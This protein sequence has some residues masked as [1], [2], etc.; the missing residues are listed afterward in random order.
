VYGSRSYVFT[1]DISINEETAPTMDRAAFTFLQQV[2]ALSSYKDQTLAIE[3]GSA[4]AAILG[5]NF[6]VT[7]SAAVSFDESFTHWG[8]EDNEF[9][10]RL[11]SSHGYE[12]VCPPGLEVIGVEPGTEKQFSSIRPKTSEEIEG[13]IADLV[14][15]CRQYPTVDLFFAWYSLRFFEFNPMTRRW[16][17]NE[18]SISEHAELERRF[19]T[20]SEWYDRVLITNAGPSSLRSTVQDKVGQP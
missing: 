1:G 12:A 19:E 16:C 18:I 6:S 3:S 5:C 9:A 13:F 17:R 8:F 2:A 11:I 7:R 10:C 15:F 14:Y 4:W 20:A